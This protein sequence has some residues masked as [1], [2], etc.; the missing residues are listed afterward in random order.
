[1]KTRVIP[2]LMIL[3]TVSLWSCR[4]EVDLPQDNH[5][6]EIQTGSV[7][8]DS[9]INSTPY[10]ELSNAEVIAILQMREEE[11]AARD[12]Y[13]VASSLWAGNIFAN[14]SAAESKHMT[15]VWALLEK[16]DLEDPIQVDV[17][18]QF[19]STMIQGLYDQLLPAMQES[20]NSAVLTGSLIEEMDIYDLRQLMEQVDNIDV[21]MIFENLERGSRNHLRGFYEQQQILGLT[22]TPQY[23]SQSEYEEI[24]N[25]PREH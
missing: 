4:K 18:G 12:L 7:H 22:Y 21:R 3:A 8:L 10:Q 5:I 13:R 2:F 1:M 20:K 24:V 14:I 6:T 17:P 23:L 19:E 16:Y 11:K 15:A 9:I 25:S